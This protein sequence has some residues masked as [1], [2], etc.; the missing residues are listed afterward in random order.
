M[1]STF[2]KRHFYI[3]LLILFSFLIWNYAEKEVNFNGVAPKIENGV[4]DLRQ[5]NFEEKFN[6]FLDGDTKFFW[7]EF[8]TGKDITLNLS[9]KQS[10]DLPIEESW[11]GKSEVLDDYSPYGYGTYYFKVL[12]PDNFAPNN[13]APTLTFIFHPKSYSAY[14]VEINNTLVAQNGVI[15]K[16]KNTSKSFFSK[17]AFTY[18]PSTTNLGQL[19]QSSQV[20]NVIIRTSEF[21]FF[22]Y[23]KGFEIELL[24]GGGQTIS[25]QSLNT[26]LFK[27]SLEESV[28]VGFFLSFFFFLV[29]FILFNKIRKGE[30]YIFWVCLLSIPTIFRILIVNDRPI[31]NWLGIENYKWVINIDA[32]TVF[33]AA[34]FTFM[35]IY[36]QYKDY[37]NRKVYYFFLTAFTCSII[38]SIFLGSER[39]SYLIPY[40]RI[41]VVVVIIYF[42]YI[43]LKKIR[44]TQQSRHYAFAYLIAFSLF[45]VTHDSFIKLNIIRHHYDIGHYATFLFVF[46]QITIFLYNYK[47]ALN[48]LNEASN[49]F[50][51]FIPKQFIKTINSGQIDNITL[52]KSKKLSCATIFINFKISYLTEKEITTSEKIHDLNKLLTLV[53]DNIRNFGGFIDKIIGETIMAIYIYE[54]DKKLTPLISGMKKTLIDIHKANENNQ[55]YKANPYVGIDVGNNII[56]TVGADT[57]MDST[58]IGNGVNTSARLQQLANSFKIPFFI[59]EAVKNYSK[60]LEK[61]YHYIGKFNL[62]GQTRFVKIYKVNFLPTSINE[63][64][65]NE[66]F[67][68]GLKLFESGNKKGAKEYFLK[69]TKELEK[70]DNI[71]DFYL[72]Q[73]I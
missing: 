14:E 15:G 29:I 44:K 65:E 16:D 71:V 8:L 39:Y 69:I 37:F 19:Q 9:T 35:I 5:L 51:K 2:F 66:Y 17:P 18:T 54:P 12:L 3:L 38:A 46:Y 30:R 28:V 55:R 4:L 60:E 47:N 59:S 57:R 62:K 68:E 31:A 50:R 34:S 20:L 25:D 33:F 22:S 49:T 67:K 56:S 36:N 52:G 72:K 42:Q 11:V 43:F 53:F 41:L 24:S 64:R 10:I 32:F 61:D 27:R 1:N 13:F 58:V 7:H 63:I 23:N 26:I 45:L 70:Q 40:F 6:F 73:C 48:H 21:N